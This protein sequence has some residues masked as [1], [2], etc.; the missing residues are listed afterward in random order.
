MRCQITGVSLEDTE[1]K[2]F[3]Q[4][5]VPRLISLGVEFVESQP[6]VTL[7]VGEPTIQL[8]SPTVLRWDNSVSNKTVARV[9]VFNSKND[10]K[11][12]KRCSQDFVIHDGVDTTKLINELPPGFASIRG[13]YSKLFVAA[14]PDWCVA[15]SINTV[16]TKFESIKQQLN[17]SACLVMMGDGKISI[18]NRHIFTVPWLQESHRLALFSMANWLICHTTRSSCPIEILESLSQGTPIIH[19]NQECVRDVVGQFGTDDPTI[20]IKPEYPW[21]LDHIDIGSV[22]QKYFK[23]LQCAIELIS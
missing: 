14:S 4:R 22:A 16:V 18:K 1:T 6:D 3:L 7:S 11:K 19:K 23:A 5:L 20:W 17:S 8:T 15:D 10:R 21:S 12:H 13:D 9:T 2:I